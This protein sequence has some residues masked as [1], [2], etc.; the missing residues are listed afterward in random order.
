MLVFLGVSI[1]TLVVYIVKVWIDYYTK[2]LISNTK[3]KKVY[4]NRIPHVKIDIMDYQKCNSLYIFM[5]N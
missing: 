2:T 1:E 5:D 3:K 4:K